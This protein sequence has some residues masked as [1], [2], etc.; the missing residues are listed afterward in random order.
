[1]KACRHARELVRLLREKW[2]DRHIAAAEIGVAYGHTANHLLGCLPSLHL[3][4]IDPWLAFDDC[5]QEHMDRCFVSAQNVAACYPGRVTIHHSTAAQVAGKIQDG[6]LG[7]VLID[8]NH[9]EEAVA[10]DIRLWWPKMRHG[11]LFTG[12]DYHNKKTPGVAKAVDAWIAESGYTLEVYPGRLWVV[13]RK[14]R[15]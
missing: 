11:G 2:G 9:Y 13:E 4:M 10:E 15:L 5:T 1:M 6:S 12:H 7:L 3:T 14:A 8:G